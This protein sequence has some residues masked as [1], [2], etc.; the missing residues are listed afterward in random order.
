MD[1][2][3]DFFLE[4]CVGIFI[5]AVPTINTEMF[6]FLASSFLF[7]P[8]FISGS[9]VYSMFITSVS[10]IDSVL[11]VITFDQNTSLR[12]FEAFFR[13]L[14]DHDS[15]SSELE[16]S[17]VNSQFDFISLNSCGVVNCW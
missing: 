12:V 3:K 15:H 5:E 6:A 1:W 17:K 8:K 14:K 16:M 10:S 4:H 2:N 11:I 7:N 13:N 9:L